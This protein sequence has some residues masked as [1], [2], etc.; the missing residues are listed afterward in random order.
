M[1]VPHSSQHHPREQ[2]YF[3][4]GSNLHLAQMAKRCPESRYIGIGRLC[5]HRFQ[6]NQRGFANVVPSPGY[7]VEGLVYLLS[8]ADEA[9]LDKHEGVPTA[10]DKY[11]LTIEVFTTTINYVGR[12][13]PELALTLESWDPQSVASSRAFGSNDGSDGYSRRAKRSMKTIMRKPAKTIAIPP[14]SGSQLLPNQCI[15]A[16]FSKALVYVSRKFRQDSKP[17]DE[18]IDRLNA[19]ILD[20]R[21]LGMSHEYIEKCFRHWIPY[22]MSSHKEYSSVQ[23]QNQPRIAG[24]VLD[25]R[26]LQSRSD[27][28]TPRTTTKTLTTTRDHERRSGGR[29]LGNGRHSEEHP[30]LSKTAGKGGS[31][32]FLWGFGR[33]RSQ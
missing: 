20:A 3:A 28:R 14:S 32:S 30:S 16:Q 7:V 6:I 17:R 1:A 5:N 25:E 19:G 9:K 13:V 31:G 11:N 33:S 4:F 21:K 26:Q 27:S 22:P 8:M 12:A 24:Y 18:Y 10:Y 15:Q 29:H 2:L 23:R